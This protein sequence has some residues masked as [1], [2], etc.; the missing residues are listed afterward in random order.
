MYKKLTNAMSRPKYD[1]SKYAEIQIKEPKK[2]KKDGIIGGQKLEM[3]LASTL[4]IVPLAA[5]TAMLIGLVIDRR[6]PDNNSTYSHDNRTALPLETAYF[7]NYSSTTLVY[8]ASLSSTLATLLIGPAMLLF[9]FSLARDIGKN[10]DEGA[11]SKLPSPYQLEL[12]I[13]LI[14]GKLMVL[15]SYLLYICGGRERRTKIVPVLWHA[16]SMLVALVLLA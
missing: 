14:D 9:S 4:L 13:R 10:S 6:M 2:S 7:V 8:I 1:R 11:I 15:W 12:L 5:L 16:C 3:L